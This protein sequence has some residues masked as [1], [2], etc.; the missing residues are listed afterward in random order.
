MRG[1]RANAVL[2]KCTFCANPVKENDESTSSKFAKISFG[3]WI[4]GSCLFGMKD[5]VDAVVIQFNKE[6]DKEAEE[7]GLRLNPETGR[8]ETA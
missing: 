6:L 3:R 5:A 7:K 1:F 4:C 8:Y 2:G